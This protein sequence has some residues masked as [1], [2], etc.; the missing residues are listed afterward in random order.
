MKP[1]VVMVDDEEDLVW[2]TARRLRRDR[3]DLDAVG[4]ADPQAALA[5][6]RRQPPDLLITDVRMPGMTGLELMMAARASVPE[7]PVVVI[8][9]YGGPEVLAEVRRRGAVDYLEKPFTFAALT[10]CIDR[11]LARRQGQPA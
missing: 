7:L 10:A 5:E 9:A 11:L 2:S 8:T 4:F 6:L 3:P 1:R